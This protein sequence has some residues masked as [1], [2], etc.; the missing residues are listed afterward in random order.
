MISNQVTG[1][2][3]L[4]LHPFVRM[5]QREDWERFSEGN[6][7]WLERARLYDQHVDPSLYN[8]QDTSEALHNENETITPYIW[9]LDHNNTPRVDGA[10]SHDFPAWQSAPANM[11]TT[12]LNFAELENYD[13]AI[14][15][16]MYSQRPVLTASDNDNVEIPQ[17][18]LLQPIYDNLLNDR[19]MVAFLSARVG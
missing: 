6:Q 17:S 10:H 11:A 14:R 19:K 5:A 15:G 4:A 8:F 1:A 18:Y 12:N 9:R 16:M 7:V 13:D 2:S 3:S